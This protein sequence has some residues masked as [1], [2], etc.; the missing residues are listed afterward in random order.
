MIL[1]R[2]FGKCQTFYNEFGL[3]PPVMDLFRRS[4]PAD[5]ARF[6]VS[7]VVDAIDRVVGSWGITHVNVESA[8]VIY[9]RLEDRDASASVTAPTL[10]IWAEAAIFH[11]PPSVVNLRA[12]HAVLFPRHA[13]FAKFGQFLAAFY[14]ESFTV[15]AP[16]GSGGATGEVGGKDPGDL[17]AVALTL[18]T[19][20]LVRA[21]HNK[22]SKA[23]IG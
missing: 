14:R 22:S 8:K 2:Q 16:A 17:A 7:I 9:P 21:N 12:N 11:G 18:P 3:I 15:K 6:V 5:I 10:I 23:F 1:N 13:L 20:I 4:S 19:A